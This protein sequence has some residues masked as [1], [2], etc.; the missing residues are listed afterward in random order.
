MVPGDKDWQKP[1]ELFKTEQQYKF[2]NETLISTP[3]I[4]PTEVSYERKRSE[5]LN[6][7]R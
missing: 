2:S 3:R 4:L 7:D 6:P 1:S 5:S